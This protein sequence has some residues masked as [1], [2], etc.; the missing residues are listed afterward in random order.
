M[1]IFLDQ[2]TLEF[3]AKLSSDSNLHNLTTYNGMP[4][5]ENK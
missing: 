2:D 3:R 5:F 4:V 1:F